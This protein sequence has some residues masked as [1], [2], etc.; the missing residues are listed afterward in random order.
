M[1]W[2]FQMFEGIDLLL[3]LQNEQVVMR[4]VL[5]LGPNHLL[6]IRLLGEHTQN[7]YSPSN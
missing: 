1:Q 4:K 2:V 3:I 6:I 5:N 7:C